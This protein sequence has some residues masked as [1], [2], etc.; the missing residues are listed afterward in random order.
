MNMLL[1]PDFKLANVAHRVDALGT[2]AMGLIDYVNS[3]FDRSVT[4]ADVEWLRSTWKGA[5][6]LKGILSPSD[7]KRALEIG[8]DA[9]MI[10]NHGGRQ[11]DCTP[12]PIDLIRPIRD[13]VGNAMQLV[14]DGGIRRGTD[15][16]KALALG[17]DS[18]SF[19]KAYLYGLGAGGQPGVEHVLSLLRAEIIRAMTLLGCSSVSELD[20]RH[21]LELRT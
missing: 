14:V 18:C 1:H 7:A 16:V 5:L 8:V 13:S 10:S 19:G 21:I 4:W 9:L 6:V 2:G 11:L 15:I 20:Q 12:A 3:Q 17:A